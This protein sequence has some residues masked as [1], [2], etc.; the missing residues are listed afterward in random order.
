MLYLWDVVRVDM[1]ATSFWA[2]G[3]AYYTPT[4][5]TPLA[6]YPA[7][8]AELWSTVQYLFGYGIITAAL[9]LFAVVQAI[10]QRNMLMR[11]FVSWFAGFFALHVVLTLNL[12][13]RNLLLIVPVDAKCKL[14]KKELLV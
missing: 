11:I 2:L 14:F 7:R 8:I 4:T 9:L 10:R 6:D 13:D 1:G 5:L 3:Q 12:F